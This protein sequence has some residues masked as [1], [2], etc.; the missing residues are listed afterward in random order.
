M[1]NKKCCDDSLEGATGFDLKL[2]GKNGETLCDM[3]FFVAN[4]GALSRARTIILSA[5]RT[6]AYMHLFCE[7]NKRQRVFYTA[8]LRDFER[9]IKDFLYFVDEER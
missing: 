6:L 9:K 8:H 5:A 2:Y 4:D 3:G 7:G 1:E